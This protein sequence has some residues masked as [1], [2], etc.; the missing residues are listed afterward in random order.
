MSPID[1]LL[2]I[3][4]ISNWHVQREWEFDYSLT[5]FKTGVKVHSLKGKITREWQLSTVLWEGKYSRLEWYWL[6]W[7]SAAWVTPLWIERTQIITIHASTLKWIS[8]RK[9]LSKHA[10]LPDDFIPFCHSSRW[11]IGT[12]TVNPNDTFLSIIPLCL[13]DIKQKRGEK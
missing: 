6:C 4:Y 7:S 10:A 11:K 5:S 8:T 2:S 3:W 13:N 12:R 1:K 9:L